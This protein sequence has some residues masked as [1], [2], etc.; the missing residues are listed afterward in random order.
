VN[1]QLALSLSAAAVGFAAAVFFCIGNVLNSAE[2]IRL[3]ATPF[4][5]FSGPL[6]QALA[7]QRA[8]YLAGAV[9]LVVSFV[10]QV[11]ASLSPTDMAACLPSWLDS[12]LAMVVSVLVFA[13]AVGGTGAWIIYKVTLRKVERLAPSEATQ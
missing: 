12:W 9:L 3:Q 7:A 1:L 5:D 11:A 10:L 2:K 6:A 8:Q 4:W 13:L